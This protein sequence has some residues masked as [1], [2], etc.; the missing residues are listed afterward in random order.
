MSPDQF[1]GMGLDLHCCLQTFQL[2]PATAL[3]LPL[4]P[5]HVKSV[6]RLR[7]APFS[8]RPQPPSPQKQ[9]IFAPNKNTNTCDRGGIGNSTISHSSA[10]GAVVAAAAAAGGSAAAGR[11][12]DVRRD[13]GCDGARPVVCANVQHFSWFLLTSACLSKGAQGEVVAHGDR[14][15]AG[16]AASGAI[17]KNVELG[18]L[19]HSSPERAYHTAP[20][21]DCACPACGCSPGSG[22]PPHHTRTDTRELPPPPPPPMV[23]PRSIPLPVPFCLHSEAYTDPLTESPNVRFAPYM[24]TAKSDRPWSVQVQRLL[25]SNVREAQFA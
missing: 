25:N 6:M 2:H 9:A 12:A 4:R 20:L 1:D 5:A 21:P 15:G 18:V 19:F 24:H 16:T 7:K 3:A 17:F 8:L 22:V 14:T 10:E 23:S 11:T 13:T